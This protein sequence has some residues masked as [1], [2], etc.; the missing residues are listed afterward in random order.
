MNTNLKNIIAVSILSAFSGS[1]MAQNTNS[2]YFLDGYLY[3]HEMNPA[4]DNE[5]N[6]VSMPA[7]GNLNL[8]LRGNIA[9]DDVFYNVNGR[10]T[11][12]MNPLVSVSEVMGNLS[13][14]NKLNLNVKEEI[15]SAGFKA[16]GGYNTVG[17]SVR[18]FMGANLPRD[19]FSLIKEG[20]SNRTYDISDVN[21]Y[22]DSYAELA[23]GHSRDINDNLRV[24]AKVKFL[25]GLANVDAQFKNVKLTLGEDSWNV[26][27][28][29][30]G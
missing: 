8:S 4:F 15:L 24:G 21:A 23:F 13:D 10:T 1:A 30:I 7:L 18:A 16:F 5:R 2:G 11:T 6:Y 27:A 25:L 17:I 26:M 22:T 12:F 20:A 14:N 19:L 9:V 28:D 29:A 3:R